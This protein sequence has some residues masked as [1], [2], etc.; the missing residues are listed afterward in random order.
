MCGPPICVDPHW[1]H[2]QVRGPFPPFVCSTCREPQGWGV[3]IAPHSCWGVPGPRGG[4]GVCSHTV[5]LFCPTPPLCTPCLQA[6]PGWCKLGMQKEGE[7]GHAMAGVHAVPP[8]PL[9]ICTQ[10]LTPPEHVMN[11][12]HADKDRGV[13][14]GKPGAHWPHIQ[15]RGVQ[16][17]QRGGGLPL[18]HMVNSQQECA[19][20]KQGWC[21][22]GGMGQW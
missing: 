11:I 17:R 4:G 3:G 16:V 14:V 9:P 10:P 7:A 18:L 8:P 15:G 21:S 5:L 1:A 20:T 13:Y 12:T 19:C 2:E 6:E 22:N